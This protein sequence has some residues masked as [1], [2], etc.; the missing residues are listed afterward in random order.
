MMELSANTIAEIDR[1]LRDAGEKY[2][3]PACTHESLGVI[4]EEYAELVESV[5]SGR[6]GA[7]HWESLDLAAACLRLAEECW[8]PR[9]AFARRSGFDVQAP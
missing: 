9:E 4:A 2:G 3:H 5:R 8:N 1:R 7:V 6:T